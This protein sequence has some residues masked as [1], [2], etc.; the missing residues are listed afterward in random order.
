MS[1]LP[2]LPQRSDWTELLSNEDSLPPEDA[3]RRFQGLAKSQIDFIQAAR[4]DKAIARYRSV[5]GA[6]DAWPRVRL[7]MLG[8]STLSHLIPG[9]RLGA[10]RRGIVL[11]IE[12]APYAQYEQELFD[13]KSNLHQFQPDIV[14]LCLDAHHIVGAAQGNAD[15]AVLKM[16]QWWQRAKRELHCT[17]VQQTIL[18]IFSPLVG[19]NEHRLAS[20]PAALVQQINESLR[21]RS[22][23]NG[24]YLLS[25]DV[26]VTSEGL[27]SWH[28][29]ALWNR[30]KQEIHPR[31]SNVYGDQLGRLIGAL[32]GRS[33]KCLVLDL[34]NT[35]WGGTVGDDG[36]DGIVL[37]QGS[38]MGEAYLDL[39][40]YALDLSKRGVVLAICS[41]NDEQ[42][43]LEPFD[44][45]PAM[46]L[47][48]GDIACFVSNWQDKASNLRSIASTLN[49]SLDSLVFIDD[50]PVERALVRRE[51]PEVEVPELPEEPAEYVPTIASAGYFE[52][53]E[54]TAE[55]GERAEL[56]RANAE[57]EQLRQSITDMRGFLEAL[58]MELA[59]AP[60]EQ[61]NLS[62]VV[63]LLNKTN[64]FNLTTY[65]FTDAEAA[66][67]V[68]RPEI[69]TLQFRLTDVYG[70]NGIVALII[71][72]KTSDE[73][74]EVTTWLMSCRVLGRSMEEAMLN[75]LVA[76]AAAA[77]C[78]SVVGYYRPSPKNAMVSRHYQRLGFT[79]LAETGDGASAWHLSVKDYCARE[80]TIRIKEGISWTAPTPIES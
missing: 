24:V 29:R 42:N 52:A 79:L 11:D 55:D 48:R 73:V 49:L 8:S 31:A 7:A 12:E 15:A 32:R 16:E 69:V 76:R 26:W 44:K 57:R 21:G 67:I 19:N 14:C 6:P 66:A 47:R 20:S 74:L 62:R 54:I 27:N 64:Q 68:S 36:A 1:D 71:G 28:D 40:R 39:Q 43:A 4:L 25:V 3:F 77:G 9:I 58:K 38:A 34:D 10:L 56:Y 75:V 30:A 78:I 22:E 5:F 2:W 45:H 59:W 18:P 53:T 33:S 70:D 51:L 63:Q 80:S 23:S 72:K 50:N 17:V 13:D 65:R 60:F 37:G 61:G 41:K 46:L 35:I